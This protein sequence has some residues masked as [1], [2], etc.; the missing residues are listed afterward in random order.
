MVMSKIR[1]V[2]FIATHQ[3]SLVSVSKAMEAKPY[4]EESQSGFEIIKTGRKSLYAKFVEKIIFSEMIVYPDGSEESVERITFNIFKFNVIPI[5]SGKLLI[6]A[7]NPSRGLKTFVQSVA[8]TLNNPAIDKADIL[9][10]DVYNFFRNNGDTGRIEVRKVS[11]SNIKLSDK[12]SAK[13]E[14]ISQG[15]ALKELK[16]QYK[17]KQ[18]KIDSLNFY[19]AYKSLQRGVEVTSSGAVRCER[20]VVDLIAEY[21]IDSN[22]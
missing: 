19:V 10:I 6:Q 15:N 1:L 9:P 14:V 18:I 2:H 16:S 3:G 5:S 21:V 22:S 7:L 17:D 13:I 11:A 8:T 20:E 4:Q 12:S